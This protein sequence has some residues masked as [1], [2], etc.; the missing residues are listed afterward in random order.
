VL[1]GT[2]KDNT[3]K[4]IEGV[5]ISLAKT[6]DLSIKTGSDGTFKL[7]N[8][9]SVLSLDNQKTSFSLSFKNNVIVF[10]S[11]SGNISGTISIFSGEGRLISTVNLNNSN[12]KQEQ[13]ALPELS[14]GM[15]VLA[16]NVSGE[17]FT[18]PLVCMGNN[19]YLKNKTMETANSGL[20][21]LRKS[22]T[23]AIV[24]T[25]IAWKDTYD[26]ARVPLKSYS[27]DT[28]KIVLAK[29]GAGGFAITSTAFKEGDKMPDKYTC[30]KSTMG[31]EP[32]PPLK[33]SGAPEGTKCYAMSFLDGTLLS[34]GSTLA[35]HWAMWNIPSTAT[36]MDESPTN[37]QLPSGITGAS[38]K[39]AM[40]DGGFFGPCPN[41]SGCSETHTYTLTLYT[42]SQEKISP[43]S[44]S[45][46]TLVTWFS[47]NATDSTKISV[48]SNAS[49]AGCP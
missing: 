45:V 17:S 24:D 43:T 48:K 41:M 47:K 14:S 16:G 3:G 37:G 19:L 2:V 1:S 38:Q 33:W 11:P 42:F 30:N 9:T 27:S 12:S 49:T 10:N 6:K 21:S 35:Y 13:V 5:T 18:Q 22:A 31:A 7:S 40:T 15:Y 26:S 46:Q 25:L 8:A 36:Q 23:T 44:T 39:S 29:K 28:V 20:V 4:G 32:S 34:R